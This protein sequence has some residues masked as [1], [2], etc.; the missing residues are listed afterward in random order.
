[1]LEWNHG[2]GE[3][4]EALLGAGMEVVGLREHRSLPWEALPGQMVEVGEGEC[5]AVEL[6]FIHADLVVGEWALREGRERMPLTY[7][8]QAVKKG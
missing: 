6:S 3:I 5:G 4:V 8:L 1:M 7:T 2:I